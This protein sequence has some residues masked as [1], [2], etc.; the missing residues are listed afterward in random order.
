VST[1][2]GVTTLCTENFNTLVTEP[3]CLNSYDGQALFAVH[4]ENQMH[5]YSFSW[6]NI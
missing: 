1:G 3:A 2:Q 6:A 4:V 5:I